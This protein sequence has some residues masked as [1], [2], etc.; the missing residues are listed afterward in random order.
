L[1]EI[2]IAIE[3]CNNISKGVIS[4]EEEKLNIRY[5]MNGT[6]KSTLSTAISLFSQGKPMDDLKPF[7]S[8]DEIIPTISIDGDIQGVRV[9]NEEFVN[10]MVFKEST[11]IDNAF[12]VF[13]RTSDYEQKRQNLDNRLLRLKVDIDEKQSSKSALMSGFLHVLPTFLATFSTATCLI[14]GSFSS[15]NDIAAFAGKLELNAAGKSI[16]NNTNYKAIIKKNNVYNIPDGLKKYSPI[17]SDD[18]MCINWI[19]WKSKGEAFDTKGICPYCSDELNTGFAEEKQTFKE[20]YKK[21]DAQN[22]K[23]MLDLFE[24]FH[25]YIP[26][27]KFDSII[28]CIKEEKEESA[29]SAILKTFMNEYVHI[30]TQLNKI[31]YFDKNVFKKTNI[32]DMDKI[33]EDMKFEKSIFNFFSSEGFYEIVDE[34]NNSIEELRKEAIDIKAAMGKLQSVLK[35][36]VAT[37]QNDINNFLESA[38]ITYQVGINLDENGQAIATLQYIHNKKLVEVDKIRKHLSWGERNA[39]SLVL[40]M[41]YAISENAKLIVLDD[42]ISSFDTNKKYAIIHRMFSK[43]SGILPRSFYKKTVLM[44]THDFEPIIDFGVVG[45]LPEDAL[46]SKFIKNNQGI[47]TE[48]AIDYKQDIKPVVQALAAYIKDDTLGIVHRIAFLRKY[49]EHNGIENYKEAYDVL[50]SLIHGRDKCK[51]VNNSEMPQA[52]IQKGCTEIK[53]WIQNFD[54]DELYKDVYNEEKLAE[55]YFA[56]TNDYLKIQLFRAL[57]EVNPSREI[58]EEDVLV[59]FINES[60][61]I[62]NDY[63]YYLDMVKFETVPEYIVKAIDDYMERTYSKA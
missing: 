27:D 49:Y 28:A 13:I 29:I 21:S 41:F 8:D 39:F 1:S 33:L 47:L 60:Y 48:K 63:A 35:Q 15:A 62:E 61:H 32:N 26:D 34:I 12:D 45:K 14:L 30:S 10:N 53:K 17:I 40:F 20:T 6:G 37:S 51:Y 19:D 18:Q 11:V 46:N 3:N 59:K 7:G 36:T 9:F 52:E 38:G 31:S 22:L 23:N 42:P 56:E 54:Y 50:S 16:K 25:K 43:Q 44:L 2:K 4:L 55:L 57:F 24:N 58:K 5:G